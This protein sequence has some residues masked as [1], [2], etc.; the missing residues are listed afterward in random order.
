LRSFEEP[1]AELSKFGD[2]VFRFPAG[3]G[4]SVNFYG[5]LL[6]D[7]EISATRKTEPIGASAELK[8]FGMAATDAALKMKALL[9]ALGTA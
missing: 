4:G 7:S 3:K 6:G 8:Q 2:Q 5:Q 9:T 1:L